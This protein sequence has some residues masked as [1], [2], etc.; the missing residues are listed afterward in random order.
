[1][2][3]RTPI[4]RVTLDDV[5]LLRWEDDTDC[6]VWDNWSDDYL[7]YWQATNWIPRQPI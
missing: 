7:V 3:T 4:D 5:I 6:L 1:M 2:T